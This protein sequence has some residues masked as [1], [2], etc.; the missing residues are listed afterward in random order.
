MMDQGRKKLLAEAMEAAKA[1]DTSTDEFSPR[2]GGSYL[3]GVYLAANAIRD[4]RLIIEGPDC[5]Y[6]KAQY[7]QGNHDLLSTMTSV[8]GYHRIVNTALHPAQM[9]AS[10]EEPLA[11]MV[12]KVAA[13]PTTAGVLISSLPMAFVTGADYERLCR[14]VTEETGKDV[15]HVRG[16]SLQG[17]WLDGYEETLRSLAKQLP[18][19]APPSAPL[20][21]KKVAVVGLLWDRNEYDNQANC[22]QIKS[23]VQESG[24]SLVSTWLN[25]TGWEDLKR[26]QEAGTILSLPYGRKA[27]SF[28]AR[29]TGAKVIELPLPFG[30]TACEQWM[31]VLGEIGGSPET[32][33]AY[34]RQQLSTIIPRLEWVVPFQFQ[35]M[36]AGYVGD[37]HLLPGFVD[38]VETLGGTVEFAIITNRPIHSQYITE[39]LKRI[40]HLMHPRQ[41]VFAREGS[42]MAIEKDVS[43][44]VTNSDGL[45]MGNSF[46]C[47]E[48]GFPSMFRHV[49]YERPFLGFDG[50]MAFADTMA[51]ELRRHEVEQVKN[52]RELSRAV[53]AARNSET[54]SESR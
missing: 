46:A 1:Q 54:P 19:A 28:L 2:V 17:D 42:I 9:T 14:G 33:Q 47:F 11:D 41:S 3:V 6:M 4:V 25:G 45:V 16:L 7:V 23:M 22:T 49:L 27:A 50:F 37:P 32:A 18:L 30:L 10:R 20:D 24:C 48:F 43:L 5:A 38:I 44:V 8:S 34:K 21:P 31:E 35:G 13:H 40:D 53:A 29:R 36:K 51:F 26:V 12:H 39:L 15:V 52:A